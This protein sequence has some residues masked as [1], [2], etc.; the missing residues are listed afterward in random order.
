MPTVGKINRDRTVNA[1]SRETLILFTRY[2]RAGRAK[3]RLIPKLG[4]EGAAQLQREMTQHVLARVWPLV[5]QRNV[6]LEVWFEHGSQAEM[7]RWLGGGIRFVAQEEGD[8][9]TRMSR[10]MGRAFRSG[11]DRAILIG[12]DC[13]GLDAGLLARTFDLLRSHPLVFGPA[14]DG[15]YY[16]VGS[17]E[18]CPFLFENVPW[19]TGKVLAASLARAR[20]AGLEPCL[21]N[22]LADVDE[23]ADL[24]VW[25]KAR[26]TNR[27]VSVVIP[28]LNEAKHL[29]RTLEQAAAGQ[30]GEIIVADGGSHDDTLRVAE[31]YGAKLV[32]CIPG[33][34]RQ[35]N[36]GAA[37]A[38]GDFLLF[39]HADTLLP[40]GYC[41]EVLD[42]FRVAQVVGTAFRF[43]VAD[44]FPGRW[45]LE[46]S[47]NLRSRLWGKPYGDQGICV[48]RWAFDELGGF[49]DL[50]I[51]EDYEFVRR[52]RRLGQVALLDSAVLTSGRRWLRLGVL[53]ATLVNQFV[54]LGYN[55][56][57]SPGKLAV[58]YRGQAGHPKP[59][60]RVSHGLTQRISKP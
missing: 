55:L 34:A 43:A 3:T 53:R 46:A 51:M 28:A 37:V 17:R 49:P 29:P 36:A 15:G 44:P 40:R 23:P 41:S 56:G 48:R 13:P 59:S 39:L 26:E 52:L 22:E 10:A 47:T 1:M 7:R 8:L 50:P 38:R 33:R 9:G 57:V 42:G 54:I 2:P 19:G 31:E 25:E 6:N 14:R 12:A 35:M 20:E 27:S 18:A 11:S 21:L 45:L 32:S 58:F 16:L 24:S 30:P 4:A 5:R 60:L